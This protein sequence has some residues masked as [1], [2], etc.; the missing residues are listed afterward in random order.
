MKLPDDEPASA[1]EPV[2]TFDYDPLDTPN[3][4]Q[5]L[6]RMTPGEHGWEC[7]DCGLLVI[8]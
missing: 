6:T 2:W 7:K 3:C 4:Y 1:I 5:C 8:G